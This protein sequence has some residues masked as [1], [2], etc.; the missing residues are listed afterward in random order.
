MKES[1]AMT[2]D[3][4]EGG[5]LRAIASAEIDVAIAT[6][7]RFKRNEVMAIERAKKMAT[8]SED[9]AEQCEYARDVGGGEIAR[10]PSIRMAEIMAITWGNMKVATRTIEIGRDRVS[11][12]WVAHDLEANLMTSGELSKSIMTSA[13]RGTPRR[14]SE[15]A[16]T[17]TVLGQHATGRRD[18]ILSLIPRALT[19]QVMNEVRKVKQGNAASHKAR[20]DKLMERFDKLGVTEDRVLAVCKVKKREQVNPEW[21]DYLFSLG[22]SVKDGIMTWDEAFPKVTKTRPKAPDADKAKPEPAKKSQKKAVTP[23]TP[24]TTKASE[25]ES[26]APEPCP[27]CGDG[28]EEKEPGRWVCVGCGGEFLDGPPEDASDEEP[29]R[30]PGEDDDIDLDGLESVD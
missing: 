9:V 4:M 10:G 15:S 13:K 26:D 1:T 21:L 11:I 14:F 17:S 28:L 27:N 30:E 20:L 23:K 5:A 19:E 12:Q 8:L 29:G 6:A 18:G 25:S 24:E 16:I 2:P 22:V 3:V 7:H